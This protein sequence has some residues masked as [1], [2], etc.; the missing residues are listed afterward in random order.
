MHMA[1]L[2][3]LPLTVS[4]FSKIQIGFI[5]LVPAHPGSPGQRAVKRVCVCVC[6]DGVCIYSCFVFN[7]LDY[8]FGVMHWMQ[9][10]LVSYL[11][12]HVV[13]SYHISSSKTS[14]AFVILRFLSGDNCK[15]SETYSSTQSTVGPLFIVGLLD[16]ATFRPRSRFT[17]Y[18]TIIL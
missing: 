7:F 10:V 5:F 2:M 3:P 4:C 16:L 1:K 12:A 9:L 6:V 17:K 8:F 11:K 18:L 15:Y 14:V 13:I